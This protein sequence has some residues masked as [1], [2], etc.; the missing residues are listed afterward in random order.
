MNILNHYKNIKQEIKSFSSNPSVNLIVVTKGRAVEDIQKIIN[1]GHIHFGENR[2]QELVP[3]FEQ[4]PK[5][6]Q[7]HLIGTLQRNKVKYI[8]P[9]VS[10]IHSVDQIDLLKEINKEAAKNDRD[11][12]CLIQVYIATEESKHGF[13]FDEAESLFK[14][15]FRTIF[16]H[17]KIKGLM[18]MA[19]FTS[20]VQ[21][22]KKEFLSLKDFKAKIESENSL[23][24]PILSMGMSG[25]YALAIE[26]GSNM[27]RVGSSIFGS[28]SYNQ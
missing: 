1:V 24:L 23:D 27:V 17:V 21:Q 8:A 14:S 13:S 19:S 16:P 18:G 26:C 11:I 2:V 4:M 7:W 12:E 28:R 15:D 6:I 25:D 5:D 10:L 20:D 22:V 3:K 9:F